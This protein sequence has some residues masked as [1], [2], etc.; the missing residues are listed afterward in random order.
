M[1]M[2]TLL[3]RLHSILVTGA[4]VVGASIVTSGATATTVLASSAAPNFGSNV[5]VLNPSMPQSQVQAAVDSVSSQQVNSQFGTQR[6]AV[7]FEP[8]T[9]GSAANPLVIQ[10]GYYTSIAGLGLS[11]DDVVIN[12]AIESFNQCFGA[13]TGLNNFWRSMS[14]L[15]LNIVLPKSHPAYAPAPPEDPGCAN[16][17]DLYA[18]S[19][20]APIRRVHINGLLFLFDYC[21][22]GFTSGGFI[23]DSQF[24]GST[25]VNGSQQQFM[26]RNSELDGWTNAVWNQVFSG[27]T[28]NVPA[29]SFPNPTFTTLATS[30]VTR[31]A[32]FL[33]QDAAGNY[34]V[35][36]PSAQQNSSGTTWAN[37]TTPGTS[38]PIDKFFV[39][40]PSDSAA[41]INTAIHRGKNLLLTPGVYHLDQPIDVTRPDSVVLGLGFATLVPTNGNAAMTIASAEGMLVSGVLFDAGPINS[42]VLLQVGDGHPR[43]D[44]EASDPSALSD[45]FF[46]IG[47]AAA[48]KATTSLIV[49][50]N[51]VILDDIWAWRADHGNGV[52]WTTNTA[53]TGVIVNGDNVTAY[54]LFVEHFQKYEVIWNGNGGE[55]V[56][57]QNEM[58]YDVPSQAA[59]MEAPGVNGYAAFKVADSVSSFAGYGMGSY[60]FFNQ[61]VNIYAERGFEVPG[62]LPAG[63]L[64]DL[65]TIFLDKVNGSGGILH[66]VNETGGSS[67]VANPDTPVTVVSYP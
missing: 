54:G 38:L 57:F 11:P 41:T 56:F 63:S 51:N 30:R 3:S 24:T 25:V 35:L 12:G 16:S 20:A 5:L 37:G 33:Y 23:A 55:D 52:G 18:I 59:W 27:D 46:R 39:A 34:N 65:L 17:N 4:I 26:V 61:H 29:Q 47:G 2:R 58:P 66:V 40:Q 31:E 14:N 67:T 42:S 21:N 19:Q 9:Y 49:N 45:V 36:V 1:S 22:T 50:S 43:S 7:L 60:S 10:V 53:D 6:F 13:C 28:G 62:T 8:G 48:G 32:P 44:N 15:T 64:H